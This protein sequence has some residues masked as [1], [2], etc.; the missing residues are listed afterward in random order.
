MALTFIQ[1]TDIFLDLLSKGAIKSENWDGFQRCYNCIV[2]GMFQKLIER[3]KLGELVPNFV[4]N[5]ANEVKK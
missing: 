1:I 3:Y 5:Q 4:Q 2:L